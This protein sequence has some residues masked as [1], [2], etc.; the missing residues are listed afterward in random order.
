MAKAISTSK[1]R[2]V[3]IMVILLIAVAVWL[4]GGYKPTRY[5]KKEEEL[6]LVE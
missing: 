2:V 6:R 3:G 1:I 5:N 4:S